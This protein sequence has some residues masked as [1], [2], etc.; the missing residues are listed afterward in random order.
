MVNFLCPEC[1]EHFSAVQEQLAFLGW[2]FVFNPRLVRGLDYYTK[3]AFEV[4]H[5]ALGSQ[6][7]LLGGGRY[8]GLIEQCGGNP[9]PGI[10]FGSGLER[11]LLVLEQTERALPLKVPRP[12]FLAAVS[13][14][15]RRQA[16]TLALQLR[17][18]GMGVEWDYENRSLKAQLRSA[19]RLRAEFTVFFREENLAQ[20][21]VSLRQMDNGTQEEVP[22]EDL[23]QHLGKASA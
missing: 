15:E 23:P 19:N 9:T 10:G 13:E 2:D 11:A 21:L 7:V 1:Q 3:T 5:G 17:R 4:M 16:Q 6:N 22:L 18:A 20:G 14:L 12:V 8:D